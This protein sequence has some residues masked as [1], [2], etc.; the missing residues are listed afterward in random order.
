[1]N[2]T[3]YGTHPND[4]AGFTLLEVLI[5]IAVLSIGILAVSSMQI[6][7]TTGNA[8]AERTFERT[9]I[10]AAQM[11]RIV[12]QPYDNIVSASPAMPVITAAKGGVDLNADGSIDETDGTDNDGDGLTD[13]ADEIDRIDNDGDGLVDEADESACIGNG[14]DDDGDGFIDEADETGCRYSCSWTVVNND[15]MIDTKTVTLTFIENLS[16]PSVPLAKR[17]TRQITLTNFVARGQK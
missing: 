13:E 6:S 3:E 15:V 16:G 14:L 8:A 17:K 4:M 9:Y 1:M 12:S 11:E 5:A 7:A 2:I 10:A